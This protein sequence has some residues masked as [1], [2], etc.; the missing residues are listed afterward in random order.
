M[1]YLLDTNICIY[2]IKKKPLKI[3]E[4]LRMSDISDV[5]ISSVTMAELEYGVTKSG[6][7]EQNRDALTEFTTPLEIVQFD[8]VAAYHYG[9]IRAYLELR[10]TP[11]GSMDMLI[12]AHAI[13]LSYIL[14][15]NNEREFQ[16]VQGLIIENWVK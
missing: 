16:R 3:L 9:Q 2:L 12:A 13:S 11:I 4:K 10:G 15:T 8:A 1:R 5:A 6:K 7:P 14:V